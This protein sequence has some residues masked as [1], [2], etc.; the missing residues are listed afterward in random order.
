MSATNN[1]KRTLNLKDAIS[2]VAG[3][4]IGSGIFI[5]SADIA[6]QTNSAW[7][8]M[9]CW[10]IAGIITLCGALCYGE[11]SSTIPD[12]GGQYIFLKKIYNEQLAFVYGWTLFAVI[13]TGTLAAVNIAFAKF[14]G[15]IFPVI[16]DSSILFTIGDYHLSFQRLFAVITVILLTYINSRGV[17]HGILTQHLFTVTKVLSMVAIIAIGAFVGFNPKCFLTN[18]MPQNNILPTGFEFFKV[19]SV[20]LVGSLFASIT[21]NN[22]TFIASEI[23]KPKRNI[24]LALLIGTLL[25][26]SLYFCINIIYLGVMPLDLIKIAHQE[27]VAAELINTIY[28]HGGMVVIAVIIAISAFGCANGM[29]LTGSRVYYKMAK[30]KLFFRALAKVNRKTKVPENS[31]WLQCLW[32]C[33]LILWGSY[34]QL[35]DYV[36]YSSLIFYAI[37]IWGIF[38]MRRIYNKKKIGIYRVNSTVIGIFLVL[39]LFVI[40]GLTFYKPQYTLPGLIITLAGFPIYIIRDKI[41]R[42]KQAISQSNS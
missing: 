10:I 23:K 1:L 19:L 28:G 14:V 7:L 9:L 36:I 15:L 25:V 37:T 30:D 34:S 26:I 41:R 22:V 11:L 31:L 38:K 42:K 5:V 29:I 40:L 33:I 18:F 21:W 27:I 4:M 2:I 3:S 12:E 20:A 39:S 16:S 17:K 6:K 32:I 24:P 8:L 13:Q 35:L